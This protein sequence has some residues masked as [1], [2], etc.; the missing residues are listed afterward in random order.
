MG[1]YGDE[2]SNRDTLGYDVV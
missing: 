1:F 2:D